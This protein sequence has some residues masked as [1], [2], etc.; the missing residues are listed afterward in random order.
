MKKYNLTSGSTAM[1]TSTYEGEYAALPASE[2]QVH[3]LKFMGIDAVAEE[4]TRAEA[5][6]IIA[7]A[8]ELDVEYTPE[9]KRTYHVVDGMM[10]LTADAAVEYLQG[11]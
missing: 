8:R 4:L 2:K 10:F 1:G 6:D 11:K 3:L 5:Y 9:L 7:K